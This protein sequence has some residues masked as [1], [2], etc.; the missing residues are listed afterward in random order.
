M[1]KVRVG[2]TLPRDRDAPLVRPRLFTDYFRRDY[3]L[4]L[5]RLQE[6]LGEGHEVQ[7]LIDVFRRLVGPKGKILKLENTHPQARLRF[8]FLPKN[9][10]SAKN[11]F[12]FVTA[13]GRTLVD[14]DEVSFKSFNHLFFENAKGVQVKLAVE[15]VTKEQLQEM[16]A[17]GVPDT[18]PAYRTSL[19]LDP[20]EEAEL[21]ECVNAQYYSRNGLLGNSD[22][23]LIRQ[24]P[25]PEHGERRPQGACP[26]PGKADGEVRGTADA[27]GDQDPSAT[28]ASTSF[29][30]TASSTAD[31]SSA[32][33]AS[34]VGRPA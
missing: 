13:G 18:R 15:R 20:E 25:L 26:A 9:K 6:L 17:G 10:L 33:T 28:C 5:P 11:S 7:P 12:R 32:S 27:W 14:D 22:C 19:T 34:T 1:F 23:R 8:H 24:G 4:T 31:T 3:H 29:R 2:L 16:E 21:P 30:P